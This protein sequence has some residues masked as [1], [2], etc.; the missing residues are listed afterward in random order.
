LTKTLFHTAQ[1]VTSALLQQEWPNLKSPQGTPLPEIALVGKSNVGKSSLINHL[2]NHK[3]VAKTSSIPGKTQ[4]MNFFL[5]DE[6]LLLVDLPGYGYAKAPESA[7]QDWS[8]AL[9]VYFKT[10]TSLRLILL[11]IDARRDPSSDDLTIFHWAKKRNIPLLV[12][13]TKTDKLSTEELKR[14]VSTS[15]ALLGDCIPF[16]IYDHK[17]SRR[18]LIDAIQ[19]RIEL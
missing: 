7:V 12:I 13:L 9:D 3:R 17:E 11:L 18:K 14:K 4:R 19:K 5:I 15:N 16:N 1:F 8:K 10:R 6:K 2:L